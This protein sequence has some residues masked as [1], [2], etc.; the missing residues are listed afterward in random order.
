VNYLQIHEF[1]IENYKSYVVKDEKTDQTVGMVFM[2]PEK[3]F[4]TVMSVQFAEEIAEIDMFR[5]VDWL[6]RQ[7]EARER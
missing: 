7:R 3:P 6:I 1:D 5:C 2:H 4:S